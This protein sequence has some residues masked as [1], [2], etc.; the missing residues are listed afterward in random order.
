M[1]KHIHIHVGKA[2]DVGGTIK[3]V[4]ARF[5]IPYES[6]EHQDFLRA[7]KVLSD[8]YRED[9]LK[10]KSEY[11]KKAKA[12]GVAFAKTGGD[13]QGYDKWQV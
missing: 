1:A 12:L 10:L 13:P 11:R 5:T 7:Q 4:D 3:A 2:K 6:K 8:K 9:W